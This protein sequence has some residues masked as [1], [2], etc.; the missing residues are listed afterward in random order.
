[1]LVP[2]EWLKDYIDPGVYTEELCDRM[3]IS[4]SNLETCDH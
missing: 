2:I 3:I 4:G 1:M